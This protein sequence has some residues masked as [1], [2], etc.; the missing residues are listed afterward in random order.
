M[1]MNMQCLILYPKEEITDEI[2]IYTTKRWLLY[3]R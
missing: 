1:E 3:A 2:N